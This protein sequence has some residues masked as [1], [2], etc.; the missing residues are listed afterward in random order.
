MGCPWPSSLARLLAIPSRTSRISQRLP[1][2]SEACRGAARPFGRSSHAPP[3][4]DAFASSPVHIPEPPPLSRAKQPLILS[5]P[6]HGAPNTVP[7]TSLSLRTLCRFEQESRDCQPRRSSGRAGGFPV[8]PR[9]PTR[10]ISPGE[11]ARS[12]HA[13]V[14]GLVLPLSVRANLSPWQARRACG[15]RGTTDLA[16]I[17]QYRMEHLTPGRR[18]LSARLCQG[19]HGVRTR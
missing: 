4:D 14:L 7:N 12:P 5:R 10:E 19:W 9:S 3:Q 11:P 16:F 1:E 6:T 15:R 13:L 8:G 18:R 17:R 2:K